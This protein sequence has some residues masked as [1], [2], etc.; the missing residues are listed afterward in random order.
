LL[1]KKKEEKKW[2]E[3]KAWVRI[4]NSRKKNME[5][6][7]EWVILTKN[8]QKQI[9]IRESKRVRDLK[10]GF[11]ERKWRIWERIGILN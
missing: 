3:E 5:V 4:E 1:E 2:E 9:K 11:S 7:I 6:K 10:W 8:S